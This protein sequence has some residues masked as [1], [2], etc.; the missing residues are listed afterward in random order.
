MVVV[1]K[2]LV[3]DEVTVIVVAFVTVSV[4]EEFVTVSVTFMIEDI[5]VDSE[6]ID[7]TVGLK[8]ELLLWVDKLLIKSNAF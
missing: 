4:S 8:I 1:E 5:V 6:T 2:S 3:T 7:K